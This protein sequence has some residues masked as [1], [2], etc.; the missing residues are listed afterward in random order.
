MT[1]KLETLDPSALSSVT[2]AVT[3]DPKSESVTLPGGIVSVAGITVVTGGAELSCRSCVLAFGACGTLIGLSVVALGLWDQSSQPAG[4]TSH[5][6]GLGLVILVISVVAVGS[7]VVF[8][9]LTKKRRE[10]RRAD[11]EDGRVA[12]VEERGMRV[13]QT[14][15]V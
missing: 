15:T 8:R 3:Y 11:R 5:L 6:L 10:L 7:Q 4:R 1:S 14:V 12:L 2:S 9:L 13:I